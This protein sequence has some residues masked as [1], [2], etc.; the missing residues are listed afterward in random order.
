M[1]KK[2]ESEQDGTVEVGSDTVRM[3]FPNER[4]AKECRS[5]SVEGTQ[6]TRESDGSFIVSREHIQEM[7]NQGLDLAD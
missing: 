4:Q 6:Y 3:R 5:V 1:G 2:K 7:R